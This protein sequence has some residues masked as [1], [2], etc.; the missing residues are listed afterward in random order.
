MTNRQC[1]RDLN[2]LQQCGNDLKNCV[3]A[4]KKRGKTYVSF[5]IGVTISAVKMN[6]KTAKR[7]AWALISFHR[8]VLTCT[9]NILRVEVIIVGLLYTDGTT[10]TPTFLTF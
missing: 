2:D 5:S 7:S 10:T 9:D 4:K 6:K 1:H 8:S 3:V